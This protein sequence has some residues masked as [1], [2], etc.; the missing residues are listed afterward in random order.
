M[1]DLSEN[2]DYLHGHIYSFC[3]YN[4]NADK[5][6]KCL[7]GDTDLKPK[8]ITGI[9]TC[10]CNTVRLLGHTVPTFSAKTPDL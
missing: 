2:H 1:E 3:K 4:K 5:S 8:N 9:D 7:I 10:L 6:W